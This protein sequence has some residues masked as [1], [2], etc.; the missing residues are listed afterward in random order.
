MTRTA[1][2]RQAAGAATRAP[3]GGRAMIYLQGLLCGGM[4]TLATPTAVMLAALLAPA[5]A[6]LVLDRAPGKPAAR[7]MLLFGGC[8]CVG[9]AIALWSN[10]Q[11]M[12]AC[13]R[14]IGAPAILGT[15]WIAAAGGWLLGELAPIGVRAALELRDASRASRLKSAR[16]RYE[17]EWGAPP[18]TD[19][20]PP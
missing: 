15:A 11:T 6:G 8:G 13:L 10:G 20:A 19:E 9:P 3:G 4:A 16:G 5:F 18:L 2:E 12:D 1:I 17:A 7:T 14:L